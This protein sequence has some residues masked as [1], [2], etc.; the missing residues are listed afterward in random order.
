MKNLL[1]NIQIWVILTLI[2]GIQSCSN[3]LQDVDDVL[4]SFT[5]TLPADTH[6]RS[7]GKAEQVNTLVVGVFNGEKEV[8]RRS[9]AVNNTSV[10]VQLTLVKSQTYSLVFWAYNDTQENY[11]ITDLKAIKMNVLP[12][13]MTFAQA[14]STD[15]FFAV[16]KDITIAGDCNYPAELIRPLAQINIGTAGTPKQTSVA[17]TASDTF[18]PFTNEVSGEE[19]FTWIFSETT[20]ETF[21]SDGSEYN[22]LAMGYLFAPVTATPV[23]V[24]LTLTDGGNSQTVAFPLVEIAANQ[25][26]NIAGRFTKGNE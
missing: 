9:F 6:T 16:K 26:S 21:S 14:E 8:Y 1:H 18:H 10:D 24:E 2:V 12:N 25:R 11:D 17:I 13:P 22:Y 19:Y 5:A 7:F 3:D 15:A 20:T 23:A 4:V